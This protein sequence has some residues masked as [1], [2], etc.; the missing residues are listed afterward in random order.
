M[1]KILFISLLLLSSCNIQEKL[2]GFIGQKKLEIK[3]DEFVLPPI[4]EVT[5]NAT[6]VEV[7][8]KKGVV[9]SQGESFN[10]LSL[11]EKRKYRIAFIRELYFVV[12]DSEPK[13]EE[14]LQSLNALEQE[15][16]RE[17]IYRSLV[18]DRVYA[19]L[20]GYE[21]APSGKLVDFSV[22]YGQKYLA[23]EFSKE[24]IQK[25]NLWGIK[26]VIVEKTLEVMDAFKTDGEDLYVWYAILSAELANKYPPAWTSKTR[27]RE[28][29]K[30]HYSWAK[31]VPFQQI[32]SEVIIKLHKLMNYLNTQK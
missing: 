20:E 7:Y 13:K 3:K 24:L 6:S 31:S 5:Q 17:G 15:G 22:N 10:K 26:R 9:F 4:P 29:Q 30:F 8:N 27:K 2:A 11:E 16:S 25:I 14:I 1:T 28:D 18:L 21:E 23:R 32:K 19:S 12:R